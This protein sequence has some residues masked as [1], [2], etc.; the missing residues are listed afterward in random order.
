MSDT[1][2]VSAASWAAALD[3]V[4]SK[5]HSVDKRLAGQETIATFRGVETLSDSE[6][7]LDHTHLATLVREC[8]KGDDLKN[9]LS[10]VFLSDTCIDGAESGAGDGVPEITLQKMISRKDKLG[11]YFQLVVR[12]CDTIQFIPLNTVDN[13]TYQLKLK[14]ISVA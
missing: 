3:I 4:V 14:S 10:S 12:L 8:F 13:G 1:I 7:L 2:E 5:P 9:K 6:F 11:N